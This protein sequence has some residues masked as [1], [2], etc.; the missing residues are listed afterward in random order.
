MST[1]RKIVSFGVTKKAQP[2]AQNN[3]ASIGELGAVVSF[4]DPQPTLKTLEQCVPCGSARAD[5]WPYITTYANHLGDPSIRDPWKKQELLEFAQ[6]AWRVA[7]LLK[8]GQRVAVACRGGKNRSRALARC[9][10]ALAGEDLLDVPGPDDTEMNI[11]VGAAEAAVVEVGP[12]MDEMVRLHNFEP[13]KV[14]EDARFLCSKEDLLEPDKL[15]EASPCC[16]IPW[17]YVATVLV[18]CKTFAA[19]GQ[20]PAAH[21]QNRK[22]ALM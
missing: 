19:L 3:L 18:V 22:R 10:C 7:V 14:F 2:D 13:Q 9:A 21:R 20:V 11:L 4:A 1:E 8:D 15:E 12:L 5:T 6:L 17:K 16:A